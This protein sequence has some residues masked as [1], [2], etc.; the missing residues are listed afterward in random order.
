MED[1]AVWKVQGTVYVEGGHSNCQPPVIPV[2]IL[3]PRIIE[4]S[5][6]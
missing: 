1:Q 6:G 4:S 5:G 3:V 2:R